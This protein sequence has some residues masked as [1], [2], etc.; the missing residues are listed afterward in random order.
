M[1][2]F[3]TQIMT[4]YSK[5]MI[6]EVDKKINYYNNILGKRLYG[7]TFSQDN[8]NYEKP[9]L[10]FDIDKDANKKYGRI[11]AYDRET[12]AHRASYALSKNMFVED[13]PNK[14]EYN[15]ILQICHGHNCPKRCIEPSH[16]SLKTNIEN[17][18]NDKIRDNTL[19]RG[20]DHY[21]SKFTSE[22]IKEMFDSKGTGTIKER[23]K[24]FGI[25]RS[26]LAN[27]DCGLSWSHITGLDNSKM[28]EKNRKRLKESKKNIEYT[29]E[30]CEEILN[31]LKDKITISDISS[32]DNSFCHEYKD[33]D[34]EGYGKIS[35]KGVGYRTH[36]ISF[37]INQKRKRDLSGENKVVRHLCNNKACCNIKHLR[38]GTQ[39][40]NTIDALENGSKSAIINK[41]IVKIVK[42]SL[43]SFYMS[44]DEIANEYNIG[45]NIILHLKLNLTWK[46]ILIYDSVH[47]VADLIKQYFNL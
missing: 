9:C 32:Y 7:K 3:K 26:N 42:F 12:S 4:I 36:I 20:E 34:N 6:Q 46:R 24:K 14:N 13:I 2:V 19:I 17:H 38:F 43:K 5:H 15:E 30:F 37:E 35:I 47:P 29:P 45:I 31:R 40:E 23:A 1:K 8:P 41:E 28:R 25:T 22:Q 18:Y 11:Y 21:K 16:L 33:L 27:I 10:L 44:N 39:S